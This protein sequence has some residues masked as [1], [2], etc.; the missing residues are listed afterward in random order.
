MEIR[1]YHVDQEGFIVLICPSCQKTRRVSVS[2]FRNKKHKLTTRCKCD[3][4]FEI[5][6]NFRK[7]YRKNVHL[8]G[9]VVVPTEYSTS[10][11]KGINVLDVSKNGLRF[12]L[13][14]NV[15][16]KIGDVVRVKFNLD[17]KQATTIDKEVII[18]FIG[19][20]QYG[21]EFKEL[22]LMEKE[23]GFFLLGG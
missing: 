7:I 3:F 23:L 14:G 21:C 6:L 2:K 12:Q 4:R 17:N 20:N 13:I 11:S 15:I 16:L 1:L 9:E 19:E 10:I 5:Q 8:T 22:G 18:R